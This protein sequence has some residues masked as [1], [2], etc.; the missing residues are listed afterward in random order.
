ML[1]RLF[2]CALPPLLVG[3]PTQGPHCGKCGSVYVSEMPLTEGVVINPNGEFVEGYGYAT[4]IKQ[5]VVGKYLQ[6]Q[7]C[8]WREGGNPTIITRAQMESM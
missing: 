1:K 5:K 6:C 2:R 8:G 4:V 7:S 3:L